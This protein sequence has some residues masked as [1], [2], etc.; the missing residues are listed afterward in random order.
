MHISKLSPTTQLAQALRLSN[1]AA[2]QPTVP[3]AGSFAQ[4]VV[5]LQATQQA[6][7]DAASRLSP[8]DLERLS[9]RLSQTPQVN[10]VNA[11]KKGIKQRAK[12]GG[13]GQ[14]A[15]DAAIANVDLRARTADAAPQAP[16]RMQLDN[17]FE[18]AMN[19]LHERAESL[20]NPAG[21]AKAE[22][23]LLERYRAAYEG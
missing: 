20:K 23:A 7:A 2:K 12:A 16:K 17:A 1:R 10:A 14:A 3:Q 13:I 18:A 19:A 9:D 21:L 6:P 15:V 5:K 8:A 22:A 11:A 4:D